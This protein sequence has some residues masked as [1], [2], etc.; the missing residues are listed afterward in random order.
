MKKYVYSMAE[1]KGHHVIEA[2][3]NSHK[4]IR[5]VKTTDGLYKDGDAIIWGFL[6]GCYEL[7]QEAIKTEHTFYYIDHAYFLRGHDRD[8]QRYKITKNKFQANIIKDRLDDRW[9]ELGLKIKPW[10]KPGRDIIVI[11]DPQIEQL[12][13]QVGWLN[14]TLKILEKNTNRSIIVR[15]RPSKENPQPSFNE[16]LQT[17][18]A[19]VAF[20]SNAAVEAVLEGIPVFVDNCSAAAPVGLTDFSKIENP[21]R[22][23]RQPWLNHLSYS[24]FTLEEIRN[25]YAWP[26]LLEDINE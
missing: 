3:A 16:V 4:D 11:S 14:N 9:R 2:I 18:F 22:P 15:D 5:L 25:G 24:Q 21:I 20:S 1:G 19:V 8:I 12:H 17:A 26:I 23:K 7:I 6:H 10:K 13:N